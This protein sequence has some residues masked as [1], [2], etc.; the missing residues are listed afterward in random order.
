MV[1]VFSK[2]LKLTEDSE[3]NEAV[4]QAWRT[5]RNAGRQAI[6]TADD[7]IEPVRVPFLNNRRVTIDKN[8]NLY[9]R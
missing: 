4:E 9:T 6:S 1:R 8:G 2:G 3:H 7:N 5:R